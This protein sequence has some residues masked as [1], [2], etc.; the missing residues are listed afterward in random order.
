M[1]AQ[2]EKTVFDLDKIFADRYNLITVTVSAY[3]SGCYANGRQKPE[4]CGKSALCGINRKGPD[5]KGSF[6]MAKATDKG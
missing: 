2:A 6:C 5:R 3:F 4:K 1:H